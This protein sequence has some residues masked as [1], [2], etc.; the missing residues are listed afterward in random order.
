L[1]G[2]LPFL[3]AGMI[4][5]VCVTWEIRHFVHRGL[6]RSRLKRYDMLCTVGE[7]LTAEKVQDASR[8]LD[9]DPAKR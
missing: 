7:K 4:G 6:R 1:P 5:N 3:V 2:C 8:D 9:F